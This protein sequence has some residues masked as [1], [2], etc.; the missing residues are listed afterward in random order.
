ML[1]KEQRRA[2]LRVLDVNLSF[3]DFCSSCLRFIL[4]L[5]VV[6]FLLEELN[7]VVLAIEPSLMCYVVG[8][9]NGAPSMTALEAAFVVR[10][11]VNG[12]LKRG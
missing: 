2:K 8:R 3:C 12:D 11:P 5:A 1:K 7:V 4:K 10:S 9:T 6:S